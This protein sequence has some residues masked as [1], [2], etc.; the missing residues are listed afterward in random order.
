MAI[1]AATIG[2]LPPEYN[3][4]ADRTPTATEPPSPNVSLLQAAPVDVQEGEVSRTQEAAAS[5]QRWS[6]LGTSLPR[7]P[8]MI[9]PCGLAVRD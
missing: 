9:A 1:T 2:K 7:V 8:P 3:S 6:V 5:G 4:G